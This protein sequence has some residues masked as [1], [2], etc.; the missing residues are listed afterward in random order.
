MVQ[1]LVVMEG[2]TMA[3]DAVVVGDYVWDARYYAPNKWR[4]VTG[5]RRTDRGGV[6][7]AL[8][9]TMHEEIDTR[10]K[11]TM[12]DKAAVYVMDRDASARKGNIRRMIARDLAKRLL[13]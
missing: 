13:K 8:G 5:V 11:L 1:E 4:E 7:I 12:H 6:E 2:E 3:A 9:Y 10:L